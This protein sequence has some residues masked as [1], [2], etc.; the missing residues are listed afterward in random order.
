MH[1]QNQIKDEPVPE[2]YGAIDNDIARDNLE[3]HMPAA[4]IADLEHESPGANGEDF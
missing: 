2:I 1:N 3:I 4:D